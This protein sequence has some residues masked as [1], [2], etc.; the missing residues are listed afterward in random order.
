MTHQAD[1]DVS[2]RHPHCTLDVALIALLTL[3]TDCV[4]HATVSQ[5]RWETVVPFPVLHQGT[6]QTSWH[7][8]ISKEFLGGYQEGKKQKEQREEI[9]RHHI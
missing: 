9:Y 5:G 4:S 2:S 8:T 6:H 7:M 3:Y 1:L